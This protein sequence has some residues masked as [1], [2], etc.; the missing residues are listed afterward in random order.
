MLFGFSVVIFWFG[1][2]FF[3]CGSLIVSCVFVL[4]C[5]VICDSVLLI[6][7][8]IVV[9]IVC[10]EFYFCSFLWAVF[11]VKFSFELSSDNAATFRHSLQ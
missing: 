9:V 10:A 11:P 2:S 8:S 6:C 3:L 7:P 5:V 1:F 4:Q